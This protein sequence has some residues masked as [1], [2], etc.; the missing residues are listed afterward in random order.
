MTNRKLKQQL[1]KIWEQMPSLSQEREG[2]IYNRLMS[3]IKFERFNQQPQ[4]FY[5]LTFQDFL[6]DLLHPWRIAQSFGAVALSLVLIAI[7]S[8][9][10]VSAKLAKPG[11]AFYGVKITMER[12]PLVLPASIMSDQAKA[13]KEMAL[14][15]NRQ[16]EIETA[17]RSQSNNK[18][19]SK[20]IKAAVLELSRNIESA[21]ERVEQISQNNTDEKMVIAAANSFK[22]SVSEIKKSLDAVAQ[23]IAEAEIDS[24]ASD[25]IK[26]AMQKASQAELSTLGVLIAVIDKNAEPP[27]A[28]ETKGGEADEVNKVKEV[29][30]EQVNDGSQINNNSQIKEEEIVNAEKESVESTGEE[31]N[32]ETINND[33]EIV[34]PEEGGEVKDQIIKDLERAIAELERTLVPDKEAAADEN[35]NTDQSQDLDQS[36]TQDQAIDEEKTDETVKAE[37]EKAA[38]IESAIQQEEKSEVVL[39]VAEVI[40]KE[41][42]ARQ[43][44][45]QKALLQELIQ[46]ARQSLE[47]E[48]LPGALKNIEEARKLL[49]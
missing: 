26:E 28:E 34:E 13:E 35:Q 43:A 18:A 39:N 47:A 16:K 1:K 44:A 30:D 14:A 48:D 38:D 9:G 7:L 23:K 3:R 12:M 20:K 33:L 21:K 5:Y 6:R 4:S 46:G 15:Q 2:Y 32:P 40:E 37:L 45:K 11:S 36:Q 19:K 31:I 10:V 41:M 17:V 27:V 42:L 29:N 8:M 22:D 24:N 49:E 25:N